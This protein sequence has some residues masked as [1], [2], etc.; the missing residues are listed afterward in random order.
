MIHSIKNNSIELKRCLENII[1]SKSQVSLQW[2]NLKL[3]IAAIL[4]SRDSNND[5]YIKP[6]DSHVIIPAYGIKGT[7]SCA[8]KEGKL[9]F[10][11]IFKQTKSSNDIYHCEAPRFGYCINERS[12]E[13]FS[14]DNLNNSYNAVICADTLNGTKQFSTCHLVDYSLNMLSLLINRNEGLLLPGDSITEISISNPTGLVF[15]GYGRVKRISLTDTKNI[16]KTVIALNENI[17]FR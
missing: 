10:D 14:I 4:M 11:V 5:L 9:V 6:T 3:P 12:T 1:L 2:D 7:V 15:K 13:R 17:S 16:I 8:Y